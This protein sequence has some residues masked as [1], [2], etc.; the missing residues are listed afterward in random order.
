MSIYR[1]S[2]TVVGEGALSMS[3][4]TFLMTKG[5]VAVSNAYRLLIL[6]ILVIL[7][8]EANTLVFLWASEI[9]RGIIDSLRAIKAFPRAPGQFG[10]GAGI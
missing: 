2:V 9:A 3:K 10:D 8:M 1:A 4:K 5:L 7:G 6:A